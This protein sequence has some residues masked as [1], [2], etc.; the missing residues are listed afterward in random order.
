M[1]LPNVYKCG[2][3]LSMEI[4]YSSVIFRPIETLN[5][6]C[7]KYVLHFNNDQSALAV[8]FMCI[9]IYIYIITLFFY[10]LNAKFISE[11]LF[12]SNNLKMRSRPYSCSLSK[13]KAMM[14]RLC[15]YKLRLPGISKQL[16]KQTKH[17]QLTI[18]LLCLLYMGTIFGFQNLRK[19][20]YFQM[21]IRHSRLISDLHRRASN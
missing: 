6:V 17:S 4:S 19:K 15:R 20:N 7:I 2:Y 11:Q 1:L 5:F 10:Q 12:I 18:F 9:F 13:W 14:Y 3:C 16:A 21:L 8:L